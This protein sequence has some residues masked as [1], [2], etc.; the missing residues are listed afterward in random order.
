[1]DGKVFGT[2][3]Y[4]I[5]FLISIHALQSFY[6][7][8]PHDTCQIRIFPVRFNTSPPSGIAINI[9]G[10]CPHGQALIPFVASRR[11]VCGIFGPGF[12]RNC[13]IDGMY[14]IGLK[15]G[16]HAYRLRKDGGQSAP[17]HSVQGFVPPIIRF[18]A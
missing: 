16:R 9:D 5:V 12:I 1:M 3:V 8:Y 15:R 6:H 14:G 13:S 2:S 10:G 11:R 17:C 7:I 18:N 4:F